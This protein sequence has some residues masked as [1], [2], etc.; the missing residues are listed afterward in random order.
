[1]I[2]HT[3]QEAILDFRPVKE[4]SPDQLRKLI[5]NFMENTMALQGMGLNVG[6]SDFIWFH[7]IAK[8]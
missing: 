3:H 6:P 7:I 8:K 5:S 2:I 1:M 4:E